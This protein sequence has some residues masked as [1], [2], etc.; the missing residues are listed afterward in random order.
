MSDPVDLLFDIGNT[1]LKWGLYQRGRIAQSG[2]VMHESLRDS[3]F[4]A[5]TTKLPRH[6]NRVLASNVA[7]AS[8]ATRFSAAV[9]LHCRGTVHFVRAERQACGVTS[10]YAHPRR[11]GVDR[12]VAM[13]A[14]FAE[15]HSAAV[16]VDAGTAI[17]ID[18]IDKTGL[19]LG[20]QILPGIGLMTTSLNRETAD[21]P[22]V[23]HGR[24]QVKTGVAMFA[25]NTNGAIINGAYNAACGAIERAVRSIRS[26]R[27]RP[28][29]ILTGGDASRILKQLEGDIEHRP[30]L[31]LQGLARIIDSES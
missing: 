28:R 25:A 5:L 24:R 22:S 3:G 21:L 1:R 10:G 20:G 4:A 9:G 12:W 18:V 16:V 27:M 23:G 17:T 2:S 26:A 15:R 8:F 11:L 31:V 14:A 6:V 30:N 19:H 7:G 29:I 13:I